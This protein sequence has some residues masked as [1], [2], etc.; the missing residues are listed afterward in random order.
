MA[1]FGSG[2]SYCLGLFLCHTRDP[3][4]NTEDEELK[5]LEVSTW[6]YGST[7]H[8]YDLNWP[9]AL[10]TNLKRR[11]EVFKCRCL[12][13]RSS[14]SPTIKDKEWAI[15]EAIDLLLEIDKELK[16]ETDEATFR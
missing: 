13:L 5:K 16:I 1:E 7:D 3:G 11:L 6:F 8:L 10:N 14:D 9:E 4:F 12:T 15:N 2:L